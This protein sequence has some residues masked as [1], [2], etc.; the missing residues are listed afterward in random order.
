MVT[1]AAMSSSLLREA[2]VLKPPEADLDSV[3][4]KR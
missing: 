2:E 4:A 1:R 3:G